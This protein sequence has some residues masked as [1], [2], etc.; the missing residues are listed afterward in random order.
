MDINRERKQTNYESWNEADTELILVL[1][2][3][4]QKFFYETWG[5]NI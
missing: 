1:S 2:S 3:L 5:I 4:T